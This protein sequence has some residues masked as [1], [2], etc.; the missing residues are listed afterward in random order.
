[1]RTG[2]TRQDE[3]TR[4]DLHPRG[5]NECDP[6]A[7]SPVGCTGLHELQI[8]RF[9]LNGVRLGRTFPPNEGSACALPFF[10]V[11]LWPSRAGAGREA[12]VS[13]PA[14][15]AA[16]TRGASRARVLVCLQPRKKSVHLLIVLLKY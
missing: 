8:G 10:S 16:A 7:S 1:M 13:A 11:L 3:R 12:S 15:V 4:A 9:I 14:D 2:K 5:V 6:D